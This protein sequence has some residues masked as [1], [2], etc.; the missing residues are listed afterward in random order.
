MSHAARCSHL[1]NALVLSAAL[2]IAPIVAA[3]PGPSSGIHDC[4]AATASTV[5]DGAGPHRLAPGCMVSSL[6]AGRRGRVTAHVAILDGSGAP[7]IAINP[8]LAH[9]PAVLRETLRQGGHA[10]L[11]RFASVTLRRITHT[12]AVATRAAV[13]V[14]VLRALLAVRLDLWLDGASARQRAAVDKLIRARAAALLPSVL[15]EQVGG[16]AAALITP[17]HSQDVTVRRYRID[18][19]SDRPPANNGLCARPA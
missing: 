6:P 12:T 3:G 1:V 11:D 13:E 18:L 14:E 4:T 5:I 16:L 10:L 8:G 15:G 9:V 17:I 19:P 2:A 7:A